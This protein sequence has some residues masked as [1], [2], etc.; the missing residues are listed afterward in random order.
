MSMVKIEELERRVLRLNTESI[1]RMNESDAMIQE[2]LNKIHE[3]E[4]KLLGEISQPTRPK[5]HISKLFGKFVGTYDNSF[6]DAKDSY[7]N[8]SRDKL[9][10]YNYDSNASHPFITA[11]DMKWEHIYHPIMETHDLE[12]HDLEF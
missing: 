4:F 11:D 5:I 2:L 10:N 9:I 12:T 6:Y 3:L 8:I 7:F 1:A